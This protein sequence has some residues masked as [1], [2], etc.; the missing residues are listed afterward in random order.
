[1]AFEKIFLIGQSETRIA[2]GGHIGCPMGTKYGKFEQDLP[3]IPT[4]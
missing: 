1:M 4:K 3:Y 2:H